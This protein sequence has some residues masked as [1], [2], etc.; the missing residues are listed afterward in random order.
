MATGNMAFGKFD[1]AEDSANVLKNF[2]EFVAAYAYEYEAIT[3]QPPEDVDDPTAWHQLN[4]RRQFLGKYSSRNF[5][6]DFEDTIPEERRSTITFKDMVSAM[7]ERYQPTKNATLANFQF[8]QLKQIDGERF[9]DFMNR[10]KQEASNCHF[11]CGHDACDVQEVLIRD[12]CIIGTNNNEIR[13]NA[14]KEQWTLADL[15][16]RG[17]QL[18]AASR[19]AQAIV[20]ADRM[21]QQ[22]VSRVSGRYSKKTRMQQAQKSAANKQEEACRNCKGSR[23]SGGNLCSA[24]SK[25]CFDCGKRGHVRGSLACSGKR[26][27]SSRQSSK[28]K[29][30]RRVGSDSTKEADA[31]SESVG[32]S[33][34][35]SEEELIK[36]LA[37]KRIAKSRLIAHVRRVS[38]KARIRKSSSRF[39]VQV[40]VKEKAIKAFA[41]TGAD[42][43]VM[44]LETANEL[45]LPLTKTKLKLRPFGSKSIRCKGSYIGTVMFGNN[46]AN[47]QFYVVPKPVETLLSGA[48][49]EALGI[50]TLN[51]PGTVAADVLRTECVE[52]E[53]QEIL[54]DYPGCLDGVGK[55]KDY[56]VHL[57]VDETVKPVALP[58]RPVPYHL[59][60][61]LE[62]ELRNMEEQGIIE[63]HE[64]PAPWVSNIVV[65]PKESGLRV[66]V[67]MRKPNQAIK[68]TNI[69]I[70]RPEDIRAQ[71]AGN[72]VFS[73]LDLKSA[74][75]QLELAPESRLL[76]VFHAGDRL[77]RYTR[78]TM[79]TKPASGELNKAL[80]PLFSHIPGAH[81][82]HDDLIVAGTDTRTHDEALRKVLHTLA[83]N[84]LTLNTHKCLFRKAKIPFWGMS[85][86]AEGVSPDQSRIEALQKAARP[87]SKDEVMSFLCMMQSYG[88]FIPNLSQRTHHLR[89]LTEKNKKFLWS[90][91][92]QAEYEWLKQALCE[93]TLL[94]HFDISKKTAIFVDAH[95]TGLSAI[96]TQESPQGTYIPISCAS[97]STTPI[98]R[99]YPQLDL[100]ALAVDF[101]L[102]RFRTYLAGGP[103]ADVFTDHKPLVSIFA[104][105]RKGSIRTERIQLRHQDIDFSVKW[106][107]GKKNP[108]D[109]LSRHAVPLNE[110]PKEWVQESEELEKTIWLLRFSPYS[111]AVSIPEIIA[112]T[113]TDPVLAPLIECIEKGFIPAPVAST[114]AE[115]KSVFGEL[116]LSDAGF[117]MKGDQ[118]VLPTSLRHKAIEKAHQGG[119][120]GMVAMKRRV[121]SHF[122]FPG[123]GKAVEEKVK[124]CRACQLF[125]GNTVKENMRSQT[126]PEKAW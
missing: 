5:Q 11:S 1:P 99:R 15:A 53:V 62:M 115:F 68:A 3:K 73:K 102:R 44:S 76:T 85:L 7:E 106:I 125:T 108:A 97:R 104:S 79:G 74:F 25:E 54:A 23:C 88:E 105:S 34:S 47:V 55:L 18:E 31:S 66:T 17:R 40:M 8:H 111:E 27:G 95:Q 49:A 91:E 43:S 96:L 10:V 69:P 6:R 59:R 24:A 116:H 16:K 29:N 100:E 64:G 93:D 52:D 126:V 81:V 32:E 36:R 118:I 77:M 45:N 13:K 113:E 103:R 21:E 20:A 82:I 33:E 86:S 42:V 22:S 65:S 14:L 60:H 124:S 112:A 94:H 50:L 72:K 28:K 56:Q 87:G 75:H 37:E 51:I 19:G 35:D 92:C 101:A 110:A 39:E 90:S 107:K 83:E 120:P 119:H 78:L 84:G 41:D 12:Q 30:N 122:W 26:D 70:P 4:K 80:L 117:I 89:S 67:D 9:D 38:P 2:L 61:Q 123:L 71:M 121:R 98:E 63:P 46:V 109:Y 58:P 114:V 48:A 57:H